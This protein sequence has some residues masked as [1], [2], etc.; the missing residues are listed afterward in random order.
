MERVKGIEP[1][2]LVEWFTVVKH[3]EIPWKNACFVV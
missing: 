2:F 3:G 1:S